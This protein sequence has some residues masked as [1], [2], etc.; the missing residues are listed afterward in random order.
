MTQAELNRYHRWVSE[1]PCIECGIEGATQ[2]AHYHGFRKHDFGG[3]MGK[4]SDDMMVFPLCH[5]GANGCH[6]EYDSGGWRHGNDPDVA[7]SEQG[8]HW[9]C[10]TFTRACAEGVIRIPK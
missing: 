7:E 1:Q 8:E 5:E 10:L 2:V 3:G 9:A 6:K 4:K